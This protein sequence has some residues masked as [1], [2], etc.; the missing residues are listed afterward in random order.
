MTSSGGGGGRKAHEES[1]YK[2]VR[3]ETALYFYLDN[4]KDRVQFPE[5]RYDLS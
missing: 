1:G 5:T 2:I 3:R 4:L